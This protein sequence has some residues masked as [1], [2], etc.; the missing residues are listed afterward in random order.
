MWTNASHVVKF[1]AVRLWISAIILSSRWSN[2]PFSFL[3]NVNRYNRRSSAS[4]ADSIS[5]NCRC[6]IIG[7]PISVCPYDSVRCRVPRLAH[8]IGRPVM[9]FTCWRSSF[10]SYSGR[11]FMELRVARHPLFLALGSAEKHS[12][13]YCSRRC[14]CGDQ[15]GYC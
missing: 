1:A 11:G 15:T 4:L 10:P 8:S 13:R 3:N 7:I 9:C 12:P 5:S 2:R 6:S 14:F